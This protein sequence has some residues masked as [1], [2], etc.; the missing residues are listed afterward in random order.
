[1]RSTLVAFFFLACLLSFDVHAQSLW[2]QRSDGPS[3]RLEF[4]SPQFQSSYPG[5]TY[6]ARIVTLGGRVPIGD[7]IAVMV[8]VPFMWE[9]V[10]NPFLDESENGVGNLYLGLEIGGS[11]SWIFGEIGARPIMRQEMDFS[12]MGGYIGD[13]DRFEAYFREVV[14]YQVMINA[15]STN[16]SGFA[17]RVRVGP[18]IF[19]PESGEQTTFIDYGG[20]AGYDNG[21]VSIIA[22][23]TGRATTKEGTG[24]KA[25]HHAG[26]DAGYR[27]RGIRP[28]FF[29][30]VPL[31]HE[32]EIVAP[33][34]IGA[35]LTV[36]W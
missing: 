7:V 28:A 18:T 19:A 32:F 10:R 21:S 17:Y 22:G 15:T 9:T 3:I 36:E 2:T 13:Y 8:E 26:L 16:R 33:R 23:V 31:D 34:T 25:F 24:K 14:A 1:M 11:D 20:K 30:R 4:L 27:F 6:S 29:I 35:N 12:G 5:S